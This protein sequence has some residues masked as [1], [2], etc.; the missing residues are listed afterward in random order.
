MRL[1][2]MRPYLSA[3][4]A[5]PDVVVMR[6]DSA[7]DDIVVGAGFFGNDWSFENGEFAWSAD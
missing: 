4:F 2:N 1:T 7:A 6:A 5:Y 3:G